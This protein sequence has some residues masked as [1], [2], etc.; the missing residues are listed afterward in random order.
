M[1]DIH[2][3]PPT[4]EPAEETPLHHDLPY[5][6]VRGEQIISIWVLFDLATPESGAV[7]YVRGSHRWGKMYS[8]AAF[9]ASGAPTPRTRASLCRGRRRL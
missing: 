3:P 4:D 6:P 5:W 7:T 1:D 8:P 9:G 2:A